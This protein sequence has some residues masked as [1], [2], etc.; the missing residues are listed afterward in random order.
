MIERFQKIM[1]HQL[2]KYLIAGGS[3]FMSEYLAFAV[4]FKGLDANVYVANSLSFALGFGVSFMLNRGWAFKGDF[5]LRRHQQLVLYTSLAFF[6]L[7]LTNVIIGLLKNLEVTPLIGKICAMV[8]IV[9]W[10]FFI[11]RL[12]IFAPATK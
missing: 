2:F 4:L 11:F 6:N 12:V 10:N 3:A 1:S 9:G 5:R 7:F 8:A